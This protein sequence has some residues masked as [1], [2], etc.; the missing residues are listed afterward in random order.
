VFWALADRFDAD[1]S[2][3]YAPS[4]PRCGRFAP[5]VRD[6]V[7]SSLRD[8]VSKL[9]V[10]PD[11]VDDFLERAER[12][13]ASNAQPTADQ[14]DMLNARLVPFHHDRDANWL[15]HFNAMQEAA[16]PFTDALDSF[17][18]RARSAIRPRR[19][20][21]RAGRRGRRSALG[22]RPRAAVLARAQ[23]RP[24]GWTSSTSGAAERRR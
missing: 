11:A 22:D 20:A 6:V 15:H 5:G 17:N 3:T 23:N 14:L 4:E 16:W 19:A 13:I 12:D 2:V 18:F 7:M 10:G 8:R 9:D 24:P 21:A 1:A